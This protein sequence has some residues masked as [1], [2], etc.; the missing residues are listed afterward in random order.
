MHNSILV[1]MRQ[2]MVPIENIN[3]LLAAPGFEQHA[4]AGSTSKVAERTAE[5]M[6]S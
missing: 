3:L 5:G 2:A 1:Q 6:H 4:A